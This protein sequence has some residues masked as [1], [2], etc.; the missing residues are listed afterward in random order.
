MRAVLSGLPDNRGQNTFAL[1][2]VYKNK[3]GTRSGVGSGAY[4]GGGL[5]ASNMRSL[6][7]SSSSASICARASGVIIK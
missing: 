4:S 2:R 3:R 1:E 7:S 6:D 5:Y